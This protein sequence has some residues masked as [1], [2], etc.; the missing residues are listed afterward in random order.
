MPLV[1]WMESMFQCSLYCNYKG[2]HSIALLSL[3]DKFLWVDVGAARSISDAQIF[4]H[5]NLRAKIEDGSI[6]IP[7]S[8]PLGLS[9]PKVN[10][11]FLGNEA[12][13][14]PQY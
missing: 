11:L 10:L 3:V 9:G 5:I 2:F 8:E 7:D 13:L 1:L 14:Q 6:G 4:K 12:L